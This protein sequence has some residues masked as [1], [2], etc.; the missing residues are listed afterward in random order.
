MQQAA[1]CG[2]LSALALYGAIPPAIE[3]KPM[4]DVSSSREKNFISSEKIDRGITALIADMWGVI[5][6]PICCIGIFVER[7]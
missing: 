6:Q 4:A 3:S 2:A 5:A 7:S 1:T